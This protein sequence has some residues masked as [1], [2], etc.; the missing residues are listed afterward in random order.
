MFVGYSQTQKRYKFYQPITRRVL[1]TKDVIFDEKTFF[2]RSN[3]TSELEVER[4]QGMPAPIPQFSAIED[5][6]E[7]IENNQSPQFLVT[8]LEEV[9]NDD[10][11]ATVTFPKYYVRHNKTQ[12]RPSLIQLLDQTTAISIEVESKNTEESLSSHRISNLLTYQK[13]SPQYKSFLTTQNQTLIPKTIDEAFNYAHWR[14]A[15]NEE[16]CALVQNLT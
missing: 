11:V 7:P 12:Q 14:E 4:E 13:A 3:N 1:V 15:M 9:Q 10:S 2:Y 5:T 8:T 6:D 16:M